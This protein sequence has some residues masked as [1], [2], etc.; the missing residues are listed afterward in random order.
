MDLVEE[1]KL[2][3]ISGFGEGPSKV[4]QFRSDGDWSSSQAVD[5]EKPGPALN[6]TAGL[7][8]ADR[9]LERTD[10]LHANASGNGDFCEF[11]GGRPRTRR[12]LGEG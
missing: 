3:P 6:A 4:T 9:I 8:K 11:C 1:L 2:L 7:E 5:H 12:P 10:T